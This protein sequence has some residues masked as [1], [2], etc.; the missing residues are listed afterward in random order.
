MPELP[1]PITI[2]LFEQDNSSKKVGGKAYVVNTTKKT[3]SDVETTNSNGNAIIDLINLPLGDGQTVKYSTGDKI[4]IIGYGPDGNENC[5]AAAMYIVAGDDKDQSLY[6]TPVV[7]TGGNTTVRLMKIMIFNAESTAYYVKIYSITDGALLAYI[8]VPATAS[9]E[10]E[11]SHKGIG[12]NGGFV[13]EREHNGLAVT[14]I[15]R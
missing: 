15:I 3:V 2:T 1:H 12:C 10:V 14:A 4:L 6:L 5:H 8:K 13:V 7:H 11:F 9:K